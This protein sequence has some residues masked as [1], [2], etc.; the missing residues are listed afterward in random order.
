[1]GDARD[2]AA[3]ET[4]AGRLARM[5]GSDPTLPPDVP[6][7]ER[8]WIHPGHNNHRPGWMRLVGVVKYGDEARTKYTIISGYGYRTDVWHCY[9]KDQWAESEAAEHEA[10]HAAGNGKGSPVG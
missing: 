4:I 2:E 10:K 7:P 6:D 5:A 8:E 1:M 3:G 9:P